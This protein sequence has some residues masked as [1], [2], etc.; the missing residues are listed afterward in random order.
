MSRPIITLLTDFGS[1]DYYVAAMKGVMAGICPEAQFIDITHD[2]KAYAIGDAAWTLAQAAP[3][4]PAGTVHLVVVDPGVGSARRPILAEAAGYRFVAPDNGVLTRVLMADPRHRI[5]EITAQRYFRS[6]VSAT[7]HGRDIFAPVAAHLAA[8]VPP[9]GFG[10]RLNDPVLI[11]NPQSRQNPDGSIQGIIQKIDRFG[12]LITNLNATML[13][14]LADGAWQLEI[15]S[16]TVCRLAANYSDV[17]PGE[18]FAIIGSTG[19]VEVSINQGSASS[20]P[21]IFLGQGVTL[22]FSAT[23]NSSRARRR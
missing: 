2:V 13:S 15:G 7:F 19:N 14:S 3:C 11:D 6:P 5:R 1:V 10:K 20:E 18:L 16:K 9:S 22:R 8:G 12:N 23:G 4:F 21:G 17:Q